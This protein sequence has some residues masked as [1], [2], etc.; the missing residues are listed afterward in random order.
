[1]SVDALPGINACLNALSAVLLFTGW[2]FIRS[3]KILQHR[4]CMGSAF[5]CSIVFLAGYLTFHYLAGVVYYHGAYRMIYFPILIT[6]TLL[7]V[8][9]PVLAIRTLF[10]A[11]KGRF[12]EHK[13]AAHWTFPIWMYVSVT[14]VIVY[15]ML[16]R[17]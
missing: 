11:V 12:E 15:E 2:L 10:L 9:V 1:L 7:A 6:H 17:L 3:G 5:V 16:Y 13:R 14:G 4:I 8:L